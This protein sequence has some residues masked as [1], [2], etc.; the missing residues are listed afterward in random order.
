[1][2][3]N[4]TLFLAFIISLTSLSQQTIEWHKSLVRIVYLAGSILQ[5]IYGGYI[6]VVSNTLI[7]R[8]VTENHGFEDYWAL[9][10]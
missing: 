7:E 9:E 1:M 4:S 2:K 5:T 3:T 10:L 6:V 8:Y